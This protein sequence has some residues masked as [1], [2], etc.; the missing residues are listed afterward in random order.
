MADKRANLILT[1]RDEASAGLAKFKA[2]LLAATAAVAGLT[3]FLVSSLKEYAE[4]EKAINKL[5]VALKNQGVTSKAVSKDL[6][7]YAS[8]LQR[9]TTFSDEAILETEA[10]LTTFGLAGDE[11]KKTT[12]AALDLST[13]LGIDLRT[14][15]L[16]LGKAAAGETGTLSRYGIVIDEN[17]PKAHKFE[18]VLGA[19]NARFGGSAQADAQTM[20]GRM[21]NF[22]NRVS[23]LQEAVGKQLVP[24]FEAWARAA[25]SVLGWL[26]KLNMIAGEN[27]SVSELAIKQLQKEREELQ[28]RIE[29]M[30]IIAVYRQEEIAQ[31]EARIAMIDRQIAALT[32]QQEAEMLA[33]E[34]TVITATNTNTRLQAIDTAAVNA[35]MKRAMTFGAWQNKNRAEGYQAF[36][37]NEK[38]VRSDELETEKGRQ[39][40]EKLRMANF[41][42]TLNF[43]SSL[44][45][46]ENKKLAA[47]G[48]AAS[49][50]QAYISTYQAANIALASAP[51]PFNFG[52]AAAV[53]AA[54]LANVSKIMG[55]KLAEGGVVLPRN[56]GTLATIGEG[57]QS[58]AVIPLG[59]SRAADE[60]KE[61]GLGNTFNISVGTL[62][63]EDGM[64]QFTKMIDKELFSLRRNN[65]SVAFERF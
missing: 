54:G 26:E 46:S 31:A 52:L 34:Q 55:I 40:I 35:R 62:V 47:I 3:S 50:A 1:L 49:L 19:V 15:T 25:E 16:I 53:V 28:L 11:L 12:K 18:A 22:K 6:Q 57:G 64:R 13:G 41:A 36:L 61:A 23:D 14:A 60:L 58:E 42:S 10:L 5:D 4:S 44:S 39:E 65:E 24:A 20:A 43:I 51:P 32:V 2:G 45:Q 21:E 9:T 59:N 7:D 30:G 29:A 56:G 48:K 8:Q 37:A 17:I 63:G 33:A 27:Q 38:Q